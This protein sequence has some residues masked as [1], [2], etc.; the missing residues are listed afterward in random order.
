MVSAAVGFDALGGA[1]RGLAELAD[2]DDAVDAD[3]YLGWEDQPEDFDAMAA[4]LHEV[5]ERA[6][7]A[8][9]RSAG[10]PPPSRAAAA[11]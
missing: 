6:P 11:R 10:S 5:V 8:G 2:G 1:L 7:A 3:I 9:A 4:A